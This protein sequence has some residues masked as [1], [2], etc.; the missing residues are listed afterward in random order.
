M[1]LD[2]EKYAIALDWNMGH[3]HI[4]LTAFSKSVCNI[5]LPMSNYE[6]QSLPMGLWNSPEIYQEQMSIIFE[7]LEHSREYVN[8]QLIISK[9]IWDKHFHQLCDSSQLPSTE[10]L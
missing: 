6:Y 1:L 3:D 9:S 2:L 4:S 10:G 7:D 5:M 8:D